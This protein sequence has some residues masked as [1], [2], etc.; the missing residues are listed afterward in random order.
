[1]CDDSQFDDADLADKLLQDLHKVLIEPLSAALPDHDSLIVI[2]P[3]DMLWL[4]P[5]AALQS[6]EGTRMVD[7]WPLVFL[8]SA[9][10]RDEVAR[11]HTAQRPSILIVANP[12]GEQ[13]DASPGQSAL[14]GAEQEARAIARLLPEE[15]ST[16]LIGK[17][18]KLAVIEELSPRQQI[19]HFATHGVARDDAPL[20]SHIQ[21]AKS[22]CD[23]TLTARRVLS[24]HLDADLVTL[25]ACQTALGK[26]SGDG[27]IG[28][29]RAF[30][31]AGARSVLVSQWKVDDEATRDLMT[32][33]YTR[34]LKEGLGKAQALRAAMNDLRSNSNAQYAH[35]NKWAAFTLVGAE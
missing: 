6:A 28:L 35:P 21:V 31:V 14:P 29:S 23:D 8:P 13:K 27:V 5:F 4:L 16:L 18:A 15:Q 3:H 10:I 11:P 2:E 9:A 12:T 7:R 25:S 19:L 24:L 34:Y 1:L 32:A 30:L 33:F 17:H 20:K 22:A 26:L